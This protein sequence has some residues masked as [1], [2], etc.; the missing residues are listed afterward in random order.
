[1][2][3]VLRVPENH[4]ISGVLILITNGIFPRS[5]LYIHPDHRRKSRQYIHSNSP[6][7]ADIIEPF[8]FKSSTL[9]SYRHDTS[10]HMRGQEGDVQ[11]ENRTSKERTWTVF[12]PAADVSRIRN[13][14]D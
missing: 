4:D 11:Q 13:D 3:S 2:Y 10:A 5:P 6:A 9:D 12:I 7:Q 1:M 14:Q 8:D